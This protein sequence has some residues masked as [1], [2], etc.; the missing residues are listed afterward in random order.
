MQTPQ[1]KQTI[2]QFTPKTKILIFVKSGLLHRERGGRQRLR[3]TYNLPSHM[4]F[5]SKSLARRATMQPFCPVK[6]GTTPYRGEKYGKS[7]RRNNNTAHYAHKKR[8]M[9]ARRENFGGT[10]PS[11]FP[12]QTAAVKKIAEDH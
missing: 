6:H 11:H 9:I 7:N 5:N 4:V 1:T 12:R 2:K 8:T 3:K 10:A